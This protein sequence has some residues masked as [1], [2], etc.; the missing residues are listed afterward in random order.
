MR[1]AHLARMELHRD[2]GRALEHDEFLLHYQPIV[3]LETCDVIG[4]EALVRW[5]HP[6]RG[7]VPPAAFIPA[8]EETGLIIP[9]GAWALHEACRQ[10]AAWRAEDPGAADLTVHV[11]VSARQLVAPGFVDDV[12][13]AVD[14]AGLSST[15]LVMEITESVLIEA[16]A[17]V[18]ARLG[19]LRLVGVRVA[20][21]DF[22]TGYSSLSALEQLPIDVLK[23]DKSFVDG[24]GERQPESAIVIA[25]T[26]MAQALGLDLVAEGIE[27]EEQHAGLRRLGCRFG[28]GYMFARPLDAADVLLALAAQKR[29][30]DRGLAGGAGRRWA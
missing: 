20:I 27:R 22:G 11:N 21:D 7:L 4:V 17:E 15:D 28:Q 13:T 30:G 2:L 26:R 8:A 9:L 23:V 6:Q 24:V 29:A 14:V 3:D 25:I 16:A 5:R 1:A 19:E 12:L 10:L 18:A